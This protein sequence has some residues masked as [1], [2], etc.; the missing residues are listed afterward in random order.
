M[1]L[2]RLVSKVRHITGSGWALTRL[3]LDLWVTSHSNREPSSYP[4][5][6]SGPDPESGWKGGRMIRERKKDSE[7]GR[8]TETKSSVREQRCL[9]LKKKSPRNHYVVLEAVW[10]RGY[11]PGSSRRHSERGCG[12]HSSAGCTLFPELH[13]STPHFTPHLY[14]WATGVATGMTQR[15][16]TDFVY[17]WLIFFF[18]ALIW[19]YLL[20]SGLFLT[21]YALL[22]LLYTTYTTSAPFSHSYCLFLNCIFSAIFQIL[23]PE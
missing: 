13:Y 8:E 15:A 4:A 23:T 10:S 16:K 5:T 14:H 20:L 6:R 1:P 21:K 7:V 19:Y 22:L 12:L 9:V 17:F 2:R 3:S 11:R 18:F